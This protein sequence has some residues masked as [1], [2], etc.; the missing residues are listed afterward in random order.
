MKN[1]LKALAVLMI[2]SLNVNPVFAESYTVPPKVGQCFMHTLSDVGASSPQKNPIA[3]SKKHNAEI[4]YVG[5]WP[6]PTAPEEMVY[7]DAWKLA[8]SICGFKAAASRLNTTKFNYWAWYTP[9][10]ESWAKGQRWLRCD[11][12]FITNS[13]TAKKFSDYKFGSWTGRRA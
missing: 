10:K 4:F 9:S 12:M 8:D 2:F 11:G 3:C 1:A 5:K 13:S 7:E 6:A